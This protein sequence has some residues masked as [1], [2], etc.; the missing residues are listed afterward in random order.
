MYGFACQRSAIDATNIS[1]PHWLGYP[2]ENIAPR[3]FPVMGKVLHAIQNSRSSAA[4]R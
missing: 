3:V 1:R 4:Q 2:Q